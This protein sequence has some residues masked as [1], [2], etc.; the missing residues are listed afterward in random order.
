MRI[1]KLLA[2]GIAA[3]TAIIYWSAGAHAQNII[4]TPHTAITDPVYIP[5]MESYVQLFEFESIGLQNRW[6]N[7]NLIAD[8]YAFQGTKGRLAIIDSLDAHL[9]IIRF[10]KENEGRGTWIGGTYDCHGSGRIQ[11]VDGKEVGE[12]GFV[13]WHRLW[14]RFSVGR[15]Q[16]CSAAGAGPM[17]ML[18]EP[19][20]SSWRWR[21]A[22]TMKAF[23]NFLIE[24][25]TGGP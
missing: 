20:D 11:W 5:E 21:V 4:V 2:I 22:G 12:S 1:Q 23:P 18:Y 10:L 6:A 8:N 19:T 17:G 3:V 13:A 14:N 16:E 7:A 24:Y 25:P 9:A 15:S